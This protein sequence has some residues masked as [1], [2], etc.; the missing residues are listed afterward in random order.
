MKVRNSLAQG[1][2]VGSISAI[3]G[4]VLYRYV[5]KL[6]SGNLHLLLQYMADIYYSL[7]ICNGLYA[8]QLKDP[9][10][11]TE[12]IIANANNHSTIQK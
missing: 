3:I 6:S 11:C 1:Q 9:S 2:E 8:E 12:E 7:T 5:D 4:N 10:A